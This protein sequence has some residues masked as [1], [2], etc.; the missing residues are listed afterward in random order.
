MA[1]VGY[2]DTTAKPHVPSIRPEEHEKGLHLTL[3]SVEAELEQVERR[4]REL[5]L[6]RSSCQVALTALNEDADG[7]MKPSVDREDTW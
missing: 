1:E 2:N 4:L 3:E 7:A 6:I 5:R